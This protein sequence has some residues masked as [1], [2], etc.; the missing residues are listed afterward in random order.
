MRGKTKKT[1]PVGPDPIFES[2]KVS[3][4]VNYVMKQ[5]KKDIARK[6]VYGAFDLIK[7]KNKTEKSEKRV[8]T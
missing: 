3:K 8:A 2:A 4:L 5:G 1:N 7:E 6:I